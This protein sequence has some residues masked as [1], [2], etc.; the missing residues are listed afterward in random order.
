MERKDKKIDVRTL[1]RIGGGRLRLAIAM[2][3]IDN[4]IINRV[5]SLKSQKYSDFK[6]AF[7]KVTGYETDVS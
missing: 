7:F 2:Y 3:P 6:L 4:F 5:T 1:R